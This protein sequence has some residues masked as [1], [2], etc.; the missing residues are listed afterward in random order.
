MA[1]ASSEFVT[2]GTQVR[3]EPGFVGTDECKRAATSVLFF[4]TASLDYILA[5][6]LQRLL[7]LLPHS[8]MH[9]KELFCVVHRAYKHLANAGSRSV[10]LT[11]DLKDELVACGLLLGVAVSNIRWP[12]SHIITCSDATPDS[13]AVCEVAVNVELSTALYKSTQYKGFPV[14]VSNGKP[15]PSPPRGVFHDPICDEIADCLRWN[16]RSVKLGMASQHVNIREVGAIGDVLR[17]RVRSNLL[18]ERCVNGVDSLV[19]LGGWAKGRSPSLQ[20]NGRL[21]NNL[22]RHV[23]GNKHFSNVYFSTKHNP[24]DD[25]TRGVELRSPK[26]PPR[27]LKSLT[28][29]RS[30]HLHNPFACLSRPPM[31]RECFSGCGALSEALHVRGVLMFNPMEAYPSKGVYIAYNDLLDDTVFQ[32]LLDMI[33]CGIVVYLHFGLDCKSLGKVGVLNGGTR[34]RAN[35]DGV[36]PL[37]QNELAG[38]EQAKRVKILCVALSKVGGIFT[39]ENPIDSFVFASQHFLVLT[40]IVSCWLCRFEQCAYGLVLPAAPPDH[41]CRKS[42]G[43]LGNFKGVLSCGRSCPGL[44]ATHKHQTAWGTVSVNGHSVSLAKAAGRYPVALCTA[45]ADCVALELLARFGHLS[46]D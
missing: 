11:D 23:P 36:P 33:I 12:V 35:P 13:Q 30:S 27:W 21:R 20:I 16:V 44:S 22:G 34:S 25:P 37:K 4:Q 32:N 18:A 19:G 45:I 7:G 2:W 41:Y 40:S 15:S 10:K 29:P 28:V 9:R 17:H 5:K 46:W 38:N 42:T 39:I 31:G 1:R 8:F 3:P 26:V 14:H 24:S 6:L 43:L